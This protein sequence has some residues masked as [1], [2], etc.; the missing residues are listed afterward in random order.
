ME[1]YMRTPAREQVFLQKEM[2]MDY[3]LKQYWLLTFVTKIKLVLP[4]T[5]HV[6]EQRTSERFTAQYHSIKFIVI[7]TACAAH[8]TGAWGRYI[9]T[10]WVQLSTPSLTTDD[11]VYWI[12][13]AHSCLNL[14]CVSDD[15]CNTTTNQQV[16]SK[17]C[18]FSQTE[19]ITSLQWGSLIHSPLW[20]SPLLSLPAP[21]WEQHCEELPVDSPSVTHASSRETHIPDMGSYLPWKNKSERRRRGWRGFETETCYLLHSFQF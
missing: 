13:A 1:C 4:A 6:L 7:G 19:S 10:C 5:Y 8:G 20:I 3:V 18:F 11:A 14:S 17:S 16:D 9:Y 15:I 21:D 12:L 2:E